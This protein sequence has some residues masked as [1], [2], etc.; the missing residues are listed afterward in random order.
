MA[1]TVLV[2][3][4]EPLAGAL[5]RGVLAEGGYDV[6]LAPTAREAMAAL[7]E[8]LPDLVLLDPP[9]ADGDGAEVA[10][11][12]ERRAGGGVPL[13]LLTDDPEPERRARRLGA[14]AYLPR[15]VAPADLRARVARTL[16]NAR[17]LAADTARRWERAV[18]RAERVAAIQEQLDRRR[19]ELARAAGDAARFSG[20]LE[21]A[22]DAMLV[23]GADGRVALANAQAE[24]LFG[25]PREE[26]FGRPVEALLPE[27][28]RAAHL[29][30]RAAYAAAPRARPMGAGLELLGLRADGTGF[31]VEISLSPFAGAGEP[32]VI[33]AVRDVG[34]RR[35]AEERIR[36][37]AALLDLARDG[38]FVRGFADARVTYW[39]AGA[40][41][42]YGWSAAEVAERGFWEG[43]LVH[44][45]KD[46]SRVEVASRWALRRDAEGRPR[47]IL[48]LNTDISERKVLERLE[49][50]FVAMVSHELKN[51]LT[52]MKIFA[53]VMQAT[54]AYN[55]RA[56]EAILSQ[57]DRLDRLVSDLLDASRLRT[58][59][60]PLKRSRVDLC[61]LLRDLV[62][63]AQATTGAHAIRLAAPA[64]P[65]VGRWDRERVEQVLGNLLSNAIKYSPEGGEIRV[66]AEHLAGAARVSVA[67]RGIGIEPEARERLFG[68]F[69]RTP[70]AAA[71]GAKG[72]GLYISRS[73][74]EAHGG[75][76]WVESAPGRGS[77]FR[78]TLPFGAP[79]GD[80]P[81]GS[82]PRV[83]RPF[84]SVKA[85]VNPPAVA[86]PREPGG[87]ERRAEGAPWSAVS[88]WWTTTPRSATRS[89]SPSRSAATRSR[90]R[91][92]GR[93]RSPAWTAPRPPWSSPT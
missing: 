21:A 35:R 39:S 42:L 65:L 69:Y 1:G 18:E 56:V 20:L 81:A 78:F 2:V 67:D 16:E 23:V 45:R 60:L 49:R 64:R 80:W 59:R 38:I 89:R 83:N 5:L 74:V 75:E 33:A 25:Y 76:M 91:S 88:W 92:T 84:T 93:T 68:R 79:E 51:P 73:L 9:L 50:E 4:R 3:E 28:F 40:E 32:A 52:S 29:V 77:T 70:G 86:S 27:R 57:T 12:L 44:R 63:Q 19:G 15:A 55:T 31:P 90:R 24:R 13:V 34:E 46:G 54:G 47:A 22:P 66:R 7:G 6:R 10:R 48:E 26:L 41:A 17:R 85:R 11:E 14:A 61:P 71:S 36:E 30:H 43:E 58:G 87:G 62:E 82:G 8:G 53:E 37:Q 72:L